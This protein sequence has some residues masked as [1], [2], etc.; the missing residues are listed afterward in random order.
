MI[1]FLKRFL[2]GC[3]LALPLSLPALTQQHHAKHHAASSTVRRSTTHRYRIRTTARPSTHHKSYTNRHGQ[4][5]RSPMRAAPAPAGA[6]A[7]CADGTYSF[8]QHRRGTCSHHGGVAEWL[9]R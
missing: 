7:K 4:R 1:S 2:L 9:S 8:S 6:T 5:V 3:A